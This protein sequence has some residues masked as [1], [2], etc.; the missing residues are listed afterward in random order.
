V[1]RPTDKKLL[2]ERT[3]IVDLTDHCTD[4][5]ETAALISCLDI[6]I[7]VDTSVAHLAG[8]LGRSTWILLPHVPDW[9]W[10]LNRDDSPW[11]PTA[12]LFRQNE[13]RNYSHVIDQVRTELA[14]AISKFKADHNA[15]A[16]TGGLTIARSR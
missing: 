11:Y 7:T 9:R 8:T 14:A 12:R 13:S 16:E 10:L 6:V 1:P 4:F 2:C 3:D 15:V 5:L